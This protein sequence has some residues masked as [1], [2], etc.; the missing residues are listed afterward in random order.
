MAAEGGG[1]KREED[2]RNGDG[3]GGICIAGLIAV[4][5]RAGRQG[6]ER[7]G[8]NVADRV[9]LVWCE[10]LMK[11]RARR[12]AHKAAWSCTAQHTH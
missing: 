2:G 5:D 8:V 11:A 12:T 6:W 3:G 1:W 7:L 10:L 4:R 9:L